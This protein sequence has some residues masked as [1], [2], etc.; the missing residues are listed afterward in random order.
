MS[1]E[2]E[3]E[4]APAP[5]PKRH[6]GGGHGAGRK[7]NVEANRPGVDAASPPKRKQQDTAV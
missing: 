3:P 2:P 1:K 7:P 5:A 6:G 4:A